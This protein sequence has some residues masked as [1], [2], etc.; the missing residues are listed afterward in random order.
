[1]CEIP[2]I[3]GVDVFSDSV[4]D[5]SVIFHLRE[6]RE[7]GLYCKAKVAGD[8]KHLKHL[9]RLGLGWRSAF[10][11][12]LCLD[13]LRELN[14]IDYPDKDLTPWAVNP[15]LQRLCLQSRKLESLSGIERFPSIRELNL[16]RCRRLDS[17]NE[18]KPATSIQQLRISQCA[19]IKDLSPVAHLTELRELEIENCPEIDSIVPI[20]KCHKLQRLQIAGKTTILNGDFSSLSKLPNLKKVLLANRKHYSH[21]GEE[22]VRAVKTELIG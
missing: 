13:T 7:L 5:V 6:L 11:T 14:V 15:K 3:S 1:L 16:F 19:N 20:A 17:L 22:L 21:T 18:I 4:T 10:E 2:D 12:A 8:F 9:E